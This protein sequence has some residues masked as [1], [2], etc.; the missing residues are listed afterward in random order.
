M[1]LEG[2]GIKITNRKKR[3][4][5][6]FRVQS[7]VSQDIHD[8][9]NKLARCCGTSESKI[10]ESMIEYLANNVQYVNWVQDKHSI[11]KDDV[12]RIRPITENGQV[13]Y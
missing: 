10:V 6:K 13:I 12:F 1:R 3:S 2:E 11:S 5:K 4:D 9:I 8:K 7:Y